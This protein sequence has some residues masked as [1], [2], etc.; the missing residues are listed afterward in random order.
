MLS[1]SDT[2]RLQGN[3]EPAIAL[4]KLKSNIK[5][6]FESLNKDAKELHTSITNYGKLLDK[7]WQDSGNGSHY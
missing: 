3:T 5:G 7:V 4:T 6:N 2:D 1:S